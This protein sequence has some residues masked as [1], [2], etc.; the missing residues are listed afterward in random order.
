[1]PSGQHPAALVLAM[2]STPVAPHR[3]DLRPDAWP[4]PLARPRLPVRV[5]PRRPAG[6]AGRPRGRR[7]GWPTPVPVSPLMTVLTLRHWRR[8]TAPGLRDVGI[9]QMIYDW[10]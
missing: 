6:A 2:P 9:E 5:S 7:S 10:G 3:P 8:V 4:A 1:M